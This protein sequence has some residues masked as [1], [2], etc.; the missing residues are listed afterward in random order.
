VKVPALEVA[1]EPG[2]NEPLESRQVEMPGPNAESVQVKLVDTDW[3][4]L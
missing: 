2:L 3:P 1:S 4:R